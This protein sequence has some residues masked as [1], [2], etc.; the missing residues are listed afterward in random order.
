MSPNKPT[1]H[2]RATL[3]ARTYSIRETIN[4]TMLIKD[5]SDSLVATFKCSN[6]N[7]TQYGNRPNPQTTFTYEDYDYKWVNHKA[8]QNLVVAELRFPY[9][10]WS[11]KAVLHIMRTDLEMDDHIIAS[12]EPLLQIT[13]F[14]EMF[15]LERAHVMGTPPESSSPILLPGAWPVEF[16]HVW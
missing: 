7:I 10:A 9:L 8:P 5:R 6:H 2:L 11:E 12:V 3:M 15:K 1:N 13:R 14:G 4:G 16:Y